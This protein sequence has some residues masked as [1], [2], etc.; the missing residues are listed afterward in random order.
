[1]MHLYGYL[2]SDAVLGKDSPICFGLGAAGQNRAKG[3]FGAFPASTAYEGTGSRIDGIIS[4]RFL[5]PFALTFD[6]TQ[7]YLEPER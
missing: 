3:F 2:C 5:R 6:R 7:V 4:H 1:M